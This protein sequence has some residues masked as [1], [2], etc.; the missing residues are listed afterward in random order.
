M[1]DLF[2]ARLRSEAVQLV[3]V[4]VLTVALTVHNASSAVR[5]YR[6]D[7]KGIPGDRRDLDQPTIAPRRLSYATSLRCLPRMPASRTTP[8]A[9]RHPRRLR[10]PSV[11]ASLH[12]L[13]F[14]SLQRG[15]GAVHQA[16][17]VE[18]NTICHSLYYS[19]LPISTTCWGPYASLSKMT[20]LAVRIPLA[21]GVNL[22]LM[23]HPLYAPM[24]APTQEL[25]SA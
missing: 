15:N 12:S 14:Q 13:A 22:T 11:R 25:L 18:R 10:V 20:M 4:K 16:C 1:G 17:V 19:P 23:V 5:W 6:I 21:L 3:H 2:L 8:L 9:E 7:I 24:V